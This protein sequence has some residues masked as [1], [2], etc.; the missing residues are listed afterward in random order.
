MPARARP[1]LACLS[2]SI[3]RVTL[4]AAGVSLRATGLSHFLANA[5]FR[6]RCPFAGHVTALADRTVGEGLEPARF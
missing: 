6:F 3:L 2:F 5:R 1:E 4:A